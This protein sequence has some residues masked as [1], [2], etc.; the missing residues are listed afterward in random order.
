MEESSPGRGG[1]SPGSVMSGP[2]PFQL[3]PTHASRLSMFSTTSSSSAGSAT[4]LYRQ[5]KLVS[6]VCACTLGCQLFFIIPIC[7]VPTRR[8]RPSAGILHCPSKTTSANHGHLLPW[9]EI[10]SQCQD[11]LATSGSPYLENWEASQMHNS[12]SDDSNSKT[13]VED[14]VLDT[15]PEVR[16]F[17]KLRR[18]LIIGKQSHFNFASF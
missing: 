9:K 17:P 15:V 11:E 13:I 3:P 18:V 6:V 16:F 4:S 14:K 1:G 7:L 12:S 2:L 10:L 8:G 5:G